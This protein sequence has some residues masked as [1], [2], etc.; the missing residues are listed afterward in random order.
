MKT[1]T[2][3][4][5]E[6]VLATI[7][8]V[9]CMGI[10]GAL[11]LPRW[12]LAFSAFPV[13]IYLMWR[14]DRESISW[15]VALVFAVLLAGLLLAQ[16]LLVPETWHPWTAVVIV[17]AVSSIVSRLRR[18][19]GSNHAKPAAPPNG[20]PSTSVAGSGVGEGPPSVA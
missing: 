16:S 7:I 9:V 6:S 20:D 5:L 1:V 2:S 4:I 8:I 15:R 14:L 17:F 10:P 18:K 11:G 19:R 3:W 12:T 13:A